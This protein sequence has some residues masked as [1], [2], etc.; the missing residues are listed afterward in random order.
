MPIEHDLTRVP[1]ADLLLLYSEVV[2]ELTRRHITRSANN[3][4]S[5]YAELLVSKALRLAPAPKSTKGYDAKDE[6]GRRYQ[7]KARRITQLNRPTRFGAI[8][9]LNENQFDFL[10]AVLFREDFTV[11]NAA[12]LTRRE[13]KERASWQQH[14]NA[15]ILRINEELWNTKGAHDITTKLRSAQRSLNHSGT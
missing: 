11:Q 8:R 4:S 3:P 14:V 1:T 5:D 15:W 10:V 12:L 13:V 2:A 7:V 9:N 6:R